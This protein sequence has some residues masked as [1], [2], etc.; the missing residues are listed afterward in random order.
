MFLWSFIRNEF[1][2]PKGSRTIVPEENWNPDLHQG[3][4]FSGAIAWLPPNPKTD[5]NLD[6]NPNLT[7]GQF[8]S[9]GNCPDTVPKLF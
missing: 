9:G 2:V 8:S 3:S 6:Q 7:G 5:P 1:N 4:I